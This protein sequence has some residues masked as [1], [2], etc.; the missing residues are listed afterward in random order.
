M[1]IRALLTALLL[2]WSAP[3]WAAEEVGRQEDAPAA[4]GHVLMPQGCVRQDTIASSTS[5]DGDYSNVK[6][7]ST[8]RVYTS[9]TVDTALPTGSNTIGNVGINTGSNTIGNVGLNAGSNAIGSVT[10]TSEVPGTG[11]TNLG[12]AED[13]AHVSGDTGVSLLC[14]RH[15]T[16]STGLGIDGD[17]AA[18]GVNAAG[19]IYTSSNTEMPAAVALADNTAN[20]TV[21]GVAAFLMCFDGTTWDR[22][23]PSVNDT[24]DNSIAFAQTTALSL[25]LEHVSDGTS[26]VRYRVYLEDAASAGG[27]QLVMSGA[28]REDT[29][30]A[31]TSLTGDYTY[32]KTD[33]QSSL[34]V[35]CSAGCSGGAQFAEDAAH[36]SGDQGTVA[37]AKRTDAAAVSSGTD[38]DYSTL[39]VDGS[40]RLWVNCG[41]GC[42]GTQYTEDVA[43]AGAESMTLAGTIRQD[44]PAGTTTTDGDYQNLKSDSIGR[45]WVNCGAGCSGGT[46]YAE[47][48]ASADGDTVTLA[49]AVRQDSIASSTTLDG[50]RAWL[51]VNSVGRLYTSATVDAALPT[52]SNTI[53]NVNPGTAAN[54]GV[55]VEDGAET[56]GANLM[57]AGTVRRDSAASSAGSD[58]DNAT[59]NT[60]GIGKLWVTGTYIED[61]A[62]TAGGGLMMAGSVRRDV[63]ASSA[64]TTGDNATVNTDA[65]G[66]LW[67]RLLDPCSALAKTHIPINIS[68]ATTTELTASL[69]G[70]STYYYVCSIDIVTAGANNVALVDDDTDN[71]ASVTAGLAGGTTAAS[72]WNFA[73]NGG[74]TKGNGTGTVFKAV[75]AN[76]VLCLVTSAATQLSGSIQVVAAP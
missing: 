67:T 19:E 8:G 21:P 3:I 7:T 16:S 46:Q 64:G 24:D 76:S 65:S 4:D 68:T 58:G 15:D 61:A 37:L 60:D 72:G 55:Y 23:F 18:C 73:A 56:A 50:D 48:S 45:L 22:C 75:T 63:A 1:M 29:L 14:V 27:E 2:L 38:G 47:D 20:P 35:H 51:K 57:M 53:G 31:T 17:Y 44:T 52:G 43:S 74:M 66:L 6:C 69:A 42:A 41:A 54:W 40:G 32:L 9:T 25:Q 26:W 33:N 49:G 62:E 30:A 34:W 10:I 70:A 5:T 28:V 12:K 39:N 11:S 36:V 71:C 59:L 13:A